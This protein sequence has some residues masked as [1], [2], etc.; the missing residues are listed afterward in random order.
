MSLFDD[1]VHDKQNIDYTKAGLLPIFVTP[2]TAEIL[3]IGQAPSLRVQSSGIMWHDASGERLR[4]WL[5]IDDNTFYHS[6]KIGVLPMDFY[7]PGKAKSGDKPPRKGIAETWH[8]QLIA[9][10]PNIKL[11][12]LIGAYAQRY[13]LPIDKKETITH[14][15]SEYRIFLPKYFPIVHP[16]PRNNIWLKKNPWFEADVVPELRRQVDHI[17]NH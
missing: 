8:R 16:S 2:P 11:T 17:L 9:E 14:V 3:I 7:Y 15:I 6:G 1:I 10:M 13:Y 5:G 12:I 4:H